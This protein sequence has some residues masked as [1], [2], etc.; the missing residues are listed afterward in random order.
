MESASVL[1]FEA[2]AANFKSVVHLGTHPVS[3]VHLIPC[4]DEQAWVVVSV[5][6]SLRFQEV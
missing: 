3:Y 4:L 6:I 2:Q 1:S 5:N